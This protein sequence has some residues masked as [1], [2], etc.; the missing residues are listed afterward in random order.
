MKATKQTS[1]L[2]SQPTKPKSNLEQLAGQCIT[3]HVF[4]HFSLK[5]NV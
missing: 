1:S 3:R 5:L 4:L 2:A